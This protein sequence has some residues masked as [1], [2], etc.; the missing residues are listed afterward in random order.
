M[1]NK[2]ISRQGILDVRI[3][4]FEGGQD[5][6]PERFRMMQRVE[7]RAETFPTNVYSLY[8]LSGGA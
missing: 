1:V 5:S 6:T 4:A 7:E 8:Y 3:S 2:R